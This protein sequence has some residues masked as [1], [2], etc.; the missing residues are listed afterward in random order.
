M[1]KRDRVTEIEWEEDKGGM[2]E[3]QEDRRDTGVD[4]H[5]KGRD[6]RERQK[7]KN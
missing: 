5:T 6:S 2:K 1:A 7:E 3:E 4:L